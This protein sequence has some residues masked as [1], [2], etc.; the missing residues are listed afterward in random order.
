MLIDRDTF[1]PRISPEAK[2]MIDA[3]KRYYSIMTAGKSEPPSR[4]GALASF[5]VDSSLDPSRF[6]AGIVCMLDQTQA[7]SDLRRGVSAYFLQ[8]LDFIIV[9]DLTTK[10]AAEKLFLKADGKTEA[11]TL[12]RLRGALMHLAVTKFHMV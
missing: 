7:I 3:A 12:E 4:A 5:K 9:D 8:V 10:E 1:G 2:T 6:D 11:Q